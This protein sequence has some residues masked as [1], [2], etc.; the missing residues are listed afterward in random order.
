LSLF[1]VPKYRLDENGQ[2]GPFNDVYC[3]GI[4]EKM[5]LHGS[6][7]TT[8]QF[9][10][11]DGCV[12]Y[13]IGREHQGIRCMFHMMNE[14]RIVVGL[15][16]QALAGNM[17]FHALKYAQERVQGSD[18]SKGKSITE[19]KVPII[20]HPDVRRMLMTVRAYAEGGRALLFYTSMQQDLAEVA[21]TPEEKAYH[22]GRMALLTPICK[23]WAS[24]SGVQA[25]LNALQVYGGYGYTADYP[26]EQYVRDS[27]IAT[28]YEGTNGIQAIDLLFRKVM[29]GG[30]K[31]AA[32][33]Q[34]DIS[35]WIGEHIKHPVLGGEVR[36]L[37][38]AA[39]GLGKLIEHLIG[40]AQK[41]DV[42]LTALGASDHLTAFGNVVVGWL[43][44]Q[45]A[46]LS[47]AK[48]ESYD[49]PGEASARETYLEENDSARFYA[50][51]VETAR[52]FIHQILSQNFWKQAQIMSNDSSAVQ[53]VF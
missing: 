14:E 3:S 29:G 30:G 46:V 18:I 32:S 31:L 50:G 11:K 22:D 53:V 34:K 47:S 26:A 27:V 23:S 12:G 15:Q 4:E 40:I 43:L 10:D 28:I 21:E 33:F 52:F 13:L 41:G 5:G 7:T 25:C 35:A 20:N 16:G 48:L 8:L 1:L 9:G 44:L 6:A 42:K 51:K 45:Q 2:N 17:Y 36:A 24:E 19:E 49:V 37:A 39:Q 38:A